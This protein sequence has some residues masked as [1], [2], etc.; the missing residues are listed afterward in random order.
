[1]EQTNSEAIK[2][3]KKAVEEE[4]VRYKI[5]FLNTYIGSYEAR[6]NLPPGDFQRGRITA[7]IEE[8]RYIANQHKETLELLTEKSPSEVFADLSERIKTLK[9]EVPREGLYSVL[10]Y[11]VGAE[12][13]IEIAGKRLEAKMLNLNHGAIQES[14]DHMLKKAYHEE[15]SKMHTALLYELQFIR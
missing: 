7:G 6:R 10:S 5:I 2:K 14:N 4:A 11:F 13:L 9:G 15:I 1:M 8:A 12:N 3:L